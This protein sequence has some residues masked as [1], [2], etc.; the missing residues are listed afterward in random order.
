MQIKTLISPI[1]II[2]GI[3]LS[4]C[5]GPT[6]TICP[7]AEVVLLTA[8]PH[9]IEIGDTVELIASWTGR[10]SSPCPGERPE[11]LWESQDPAV[12]EVSEIESSGSTALAVG[13]GSGSTIVELTTEPAITIFQIPITVQ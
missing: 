8:G 3:L 6:E 10:S 7:P 11:F 9:S 2:A 5:N 12:V 4:A 1:L 13:V